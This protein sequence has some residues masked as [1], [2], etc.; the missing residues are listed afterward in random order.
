MRETVSL[1]IGVMLLIALFQVFS[2]EGLC[3]TLTIDGKSQ[4]HCISIAD[5]KP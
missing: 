1:V 2:K 3:L 5:G 4:A